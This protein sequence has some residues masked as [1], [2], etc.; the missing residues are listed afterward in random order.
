MR[1]RNHHDFGHGLRD[2]T[3]ED[4]NCLSCQREKHDGDTPDISDATGARQVQDRAGN[5][6]RPYRIT[7]HFTDGTTRINDVDES[8]EVHEYARMRSSKSDVVRVDVLTSY[9][10]GRQAATAYTCGAVSVAEPE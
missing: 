2:G 5:T 9:A 4:I 8:F 7:V 6:R 1:I 3:D 10:D